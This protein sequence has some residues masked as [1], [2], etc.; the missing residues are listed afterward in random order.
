MWW[1]PGWEQGGKAA[2]WL[3]QLQKLL[4]QLPTHLRDAWLPVNSR[5]SSQHSPRWNQW[6]WTLDDAELSCHTC[7]L[8]PQFKCPESFP[9]STQPIYW[10]SRKVSFLTWFANTSSE[11]ARL[12]STTLSVPSGVSRPGS[13]PSYYFWLIAG[14]HFAIIKIWYYLLTETSS[15]Y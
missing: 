1:F 10:L 2:V 12:A 15:F 6:A 11:T 3:G 7:Q 8:E 4:T 14:I 13:L 5:W 9:G